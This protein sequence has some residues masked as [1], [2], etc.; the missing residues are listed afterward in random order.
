MPSPLLSQDVTEKLDL[1]P[2]PADE[3]GACVFSWKRG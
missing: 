1:M 3:R 2:P